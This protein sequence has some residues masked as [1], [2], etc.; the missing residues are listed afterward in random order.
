MPTPARVPVTARIQ[1]DLQKRAR[2]KAAIED[3][4]YGEY[5]EDLIEKDTADIAHLTDVEEDC[6]VHHG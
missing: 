6:E 4:S 5:L 2:V 1:R 3:K